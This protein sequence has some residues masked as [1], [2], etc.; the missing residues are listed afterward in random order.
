MLTKTELKEIL[1]NEFNI[2][3]EELDN[4][5][6]DTNILECGLLDSFDFVQFLLILSE[7]SGIDFDFSVTPPETLTSIEKIAIHFSN[8]AL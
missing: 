6:D 5:N 7:K 3:K 8:S 2:S 1:N 4:L